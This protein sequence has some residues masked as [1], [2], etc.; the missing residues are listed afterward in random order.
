M[1]KEVKEEGKSVV[2]ERD[3]IM[4]YHQARDCR[5]RMKSQFTPR[6]KKN[7]MPELMSIP[8]RTENFILT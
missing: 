3:M 1:R 4:Q 2:K 8:I 6:Q 5:Q 7:E